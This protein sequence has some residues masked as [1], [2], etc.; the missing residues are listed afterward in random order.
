MQAVRGAAGG[1][2]QFQEC[3]KRELQAAR[4]QEATFVREFSKEDFN[5]LVHGWE[6]SRRP[7]LPLRS[8]MGNS[9]SSTL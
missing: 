9:M 1:M 6:V 3:L 5:H 4:Q 8:C 2:M 7:P